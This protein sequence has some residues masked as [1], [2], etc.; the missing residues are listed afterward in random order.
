M[1]EKQIKKG[2]SQQP[3]FDVNKLAQSMGLNKENIYEGLKQS[4]MDLAANKDNI[5]KMVQDSKKTIEDIKN[6]GQGLFNF[7]QK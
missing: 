5:A 1:V 6:I 4:A 2:A 3:A 7:F